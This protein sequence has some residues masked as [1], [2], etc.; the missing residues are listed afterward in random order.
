MLPW[1]AVGVSA[2]LLGSIPSGL[3]IGR[4]VFGIDPR[5]YGSRRT[6][7]TNVLRTM[8]TK[9][10]L[11]VLV[12]DV[13][14]GVAAVALARAL[15]PY[16]PWGHVLAAFSAAA[17]HNWPLFSGFRGGKGVIVSATGVGM[18]YW[19]ILAAIVPL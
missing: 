14:K 18:L 9:A 7:A 3:W 5:E 2:Y 8:G 10:A 16:E 13:A 11:A 4:L 1:I 17:G 19:P 15:M 12:L 6:G